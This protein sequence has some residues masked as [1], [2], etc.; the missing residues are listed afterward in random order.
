MISLERHSG[1]CNTVND[2]SAKICVPNKGKDVNV[3]VL[4]MMKRINESEAL[5]KRISCDFKRKCDST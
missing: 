2:L 1:S 4:N 3:K 5:L